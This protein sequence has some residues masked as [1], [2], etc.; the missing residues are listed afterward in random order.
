MNLSTFGTSRGQNTCSKLIKFVILGWWCLTI[1]QMLG[2]KLS[3][4]YFPSTYLCESEFCTFRT[5][6]ENIKTD[7]T[8]RQKTI[9]DALF[10]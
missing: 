6:K 1:V 2:K 3:D 4:S 5:C 7:S 10:P 9:L 8:L